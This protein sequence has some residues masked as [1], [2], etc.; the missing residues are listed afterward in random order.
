MKAR[1]THQAFA[2]KSDLKLVAQHPAIYKLALKALYPA[3][4]LTQT[5]P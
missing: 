3:L 4:C 5:H 1:F 2:R